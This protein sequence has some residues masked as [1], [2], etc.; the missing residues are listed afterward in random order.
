MDIG[1]G[2]NLRQTAFQVFSDKLTECWNVDE[3][4]FN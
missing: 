3:K 1:A 2:S 4:Q